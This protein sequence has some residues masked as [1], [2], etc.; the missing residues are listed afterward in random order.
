MEYVFRCLSELTTDLLIVITQSFQY[1]FR[2]MKFF[3][4][5]VFTSLL[6]NFILADR[7]SAFHQTVV[8]VTILS[9]ITVFYA[10]FANEWKHL[11]H[12]LVLDNCIETLQGKGK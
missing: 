7:A 12:T 6:C 4:V 5:G 2:N 1:R 8:I 11:R 9:S 10:V 3:V